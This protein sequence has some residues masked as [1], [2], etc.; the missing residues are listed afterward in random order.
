MAPG[1]SATTLLGL[2]AP[3]IL[4]GAAVLLGRMR[5]RLVAADDKAAPDD[6]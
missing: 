1:L 3:L 4:L 6:A 5:H 2:S